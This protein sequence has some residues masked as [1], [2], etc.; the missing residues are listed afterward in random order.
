MNH[1]QMLQAAKTRLWDGTGG[2]ET[3][4]KTEFICI[5]V[6]L[7]VPDEHEIERA[8]LKRTITQRCY[9]ANTFLGWLR[10]HGVSTLDLEDDVRLQAHRLAWI[11]KMIEEAKGNGGW[12]LNAGPHGRGYVI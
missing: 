1:V 8:K 2:E 5:A 4:D 9:P 7:A 6:L 11:D 3:P 10:E 12:L